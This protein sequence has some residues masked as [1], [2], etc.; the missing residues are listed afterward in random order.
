MGSG[1]ESLL[2]GTASCRIA[3]QGVDELF[4]EYKKQS[5]IYSPTTVVQAQT[6]GSREFPALDHLRNLIGFYEKT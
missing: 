6:R 2:T 4:E 1:A 5:V 3:V